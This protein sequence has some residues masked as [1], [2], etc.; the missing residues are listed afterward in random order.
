MANPNSRAYL[1]VH[2][3]INKQYPCKRKQCNNIMITFLKLKSLPYK[4]ID[5][6][7]YGAGNG[8][9]QNAILIQEHWSEFRKWFND[10]GYK[11]MN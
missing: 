5:P 10:T 9:D 11:L 7:H 4:T 2:S 6:K 1:G 8:D 3:F